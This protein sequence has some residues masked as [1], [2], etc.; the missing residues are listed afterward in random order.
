[1]VEVR[2]ARED[3]P[4]GARVWPARAVGQEKKKVDGESFQGQIQNGIR[5]L[6]I[7]ITFAEA[8]QNS[9]TIYGVS[10]ENWLVSD[11]SLFAYS[12]R[13]HRTLNEKWK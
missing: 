12:P 4:N 2:Q 6:E 10:H 5:K 8:L 7:T 1:M 11:V 13:L 9:S 3:E